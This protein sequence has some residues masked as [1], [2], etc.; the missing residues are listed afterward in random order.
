[1]YLY[2][3]KK[4]DYLNSLNRVQEKVIYSNFS[5]QI[6]NDMIAIELN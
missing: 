2:E 5:L 1:M 3:P 6:Q 4:R